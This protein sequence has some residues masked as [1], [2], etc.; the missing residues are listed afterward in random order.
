M[1]GYMT[2]HQVG[3]KLT[4]PLKC[5]LVKLNCI[6]KCSLNINI[7]PSRPQHGIAMNQI[8]LLYNGKWRCC[9]APGKALFR[10]FPLGPGHE[11]VHSRFIV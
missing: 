1:L 3:I 8:I 10:H 11:K 4:S 7:V 6:V 9:C 2:P 5:L